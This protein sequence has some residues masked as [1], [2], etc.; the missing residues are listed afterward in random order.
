MTKTLYLSAFATLMFSL[1]G[2]TDSISLSEITPNEP[3]Y[4]TVSFLKPNPCDVIQ[5][6]STTVN[7]GRIVIRIM[8]EP[9]PADQFCNQVRSE[10]LITVPI[11]A[12]PEGSYALSV[13][14]LEKTSETEV[15]FSIPLSEP[16]VAI[17]PLGA[18]HTEIHVPEVDAG[19][20]FTVTNLF[21]KR[22]T[23][24][25]I[26]LLS[27][28]ASESSLLIEVEQ[29]DARDLGFDQLCL[30]VISEYPLA[31]PMPALPPRTYS[32]EILK[33]TPKRSLQKQFEIPYEGD[34]A[35]SLD[36]TFKPLTPPS[37]GIEPPFE[38][39]IVPFEPIDLPEY[40]INPPSEPVVIPPEY[41]IAPSEET[42]FFCPRILHQ[43]CRR[44][45]ASV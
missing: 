2:H 16:I 13:L 30:D 37:F 33:Y 40:G 23:C 27:A 44:N 4:V 6:H 34:P 18:L 5:F 10:E 7:D 32:L 9:E 25:S 8:D 12:L 11:P 38:P 28:S 42:P 41:T 21:T 15:A 3:F 19:E 20:A 31:V 36:Q 35:P 26:S 14:L 45:L 17:H 43:S 39:I 29:V 22:T 24:E 1:Q